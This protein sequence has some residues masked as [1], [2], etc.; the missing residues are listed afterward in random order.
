M[1]NVYR[2]AKGMLLFGFVFPRHFAYHHQAAYAD[3]YIQPICEEAPQV[4]HDFGDK[5][6]S[7]LH[8]FV[9]FFLINR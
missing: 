9:P 3:S 6:T 1:R 5:D 2:Q 7:L 4:G 8:L